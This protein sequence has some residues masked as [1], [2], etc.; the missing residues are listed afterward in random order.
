MSEPVLNINFRILPFGKAILELKST[1]HIKEEKPPQH[2]IYAEPKTTDTGV[3]E[4]IFGS[5]NYIVPK[6][7]GGIF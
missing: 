5:D 3:V 4:I 7:T 2:V 6:T 1:E